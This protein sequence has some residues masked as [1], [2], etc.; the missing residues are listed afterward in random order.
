MGQTSQWGDIDSLEMMDLEGH[1]FSGDTLLTQVMDSKFKLV[2]N[3]K[4]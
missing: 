2:I 1:H 3:G 4:Y